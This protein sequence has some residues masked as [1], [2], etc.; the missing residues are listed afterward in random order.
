VKGKGV[1]KVKSYFE[2]DAFNF[3]NGRFRITDWKIVLNGKKQRNFLLI[4]I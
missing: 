4:E 3:W 1:E 2:I